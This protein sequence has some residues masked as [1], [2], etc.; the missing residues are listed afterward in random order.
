LASLFAA[1]ALFLGIHVL[2]S[3]TPLRDVIIGRIGENPY[4]GV[5]SLTSLGAIVWMSMAYG[6]ADYVELWDLGA[7]ARHLSLVIMPLAFI[8]VVGAFATPS[9]T[10]AGMEGALAS[11]RAGHGIQAITRHPFLWGV[12]LWA[13]AH[14][15]ANGDLASLVLFGTML[16]LALIGPPLIDAKRAESQGDAWQNYAAKTS[17]LP[18]SAIA[19]G[20]AKLSL[21]EIGWL[22][23]VVGL[24]LYAVS[25]LT[26]AFVFGV[27]ALPL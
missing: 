2:I 23:I 4:K 21:K 17:N 20:H 3:G 19:S 22:P 8:L 15:L 16:A 18:F 10:V 11:S 25:L 7:G 1:A 14:L 6:A 9:P 13:L 5:F 12:V 26:H 27:S 24:A